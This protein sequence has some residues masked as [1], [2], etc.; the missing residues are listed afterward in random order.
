MPATVGAPRENHIRPCSV[1]NKG[2][3]VLFRYDVISSREGT[4]PHLC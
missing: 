3:I 2:Y 4:T 1:Y